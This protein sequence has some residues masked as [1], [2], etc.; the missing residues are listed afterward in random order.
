MRIGF[1]EG[2]WVGMAATLILLIL[3]AKTSMWILDDA[4]ARQGWKGESCQCR[5]LEKAKVQP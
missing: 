5:K 2:L 4:C 3:V 1:V